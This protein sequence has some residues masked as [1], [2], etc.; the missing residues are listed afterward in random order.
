MLERYDELIV[1]QLGPRVWRTQEL[2]GHWQRYRIT[3]NGYLIHPSKEIN[4]PVKRTGLLHFYGTEQ[5]CHK[6]N[7]GASGILSAKLKNDRHY[8]MY[9]H[10]GLMIKLEQNYGE[11]WGPAMTYDQ[12]FKLQESFRIMF[13][14]LSE[15]KRKVK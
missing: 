8:R 5:Y 6:I 11:S 3:E 2:S 15:W 4:Y 13:P 14:P 9:L 12:A 7:L 1:P 10:E